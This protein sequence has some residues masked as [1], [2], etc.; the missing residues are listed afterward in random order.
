MSEIR[1]LSP[2][3][4]LNKSWHVNKVDFTKG[5]RIVIRGQE[6]NYV[7][8]P[9]RA[10]IQKHEVD[11]CYY[12]NINSGEMIPCYL[13]VPCQKCILCKDK[14]AVD[15]ATRVTCEGNYH[16]NCPWWITNTYNFLALPELGLQKRDFQ[17]FMKRLRERVSRVIGEDVRLRFVGVGEYGGNTARAHYHSVVYGLPSLPAKDILHLIEN[18]WS[19]RISIKRYKEI[20]SLYGKKAEDYT[21]TRLDKNGKLMYYL[22][23]GFVYVKPA[24]DSTPLYLAKYMFKP[25]F[26]TPE[27]MNPNFFLASRKNGIG[28]QYIVEFCKYHRQNPHCTK[29]DFINKHTGKMCHFTIPQYFKD[30][31]FPTPSKICPNEVK[32]AHDSFRELY[33][34]IEW[35]KGKFNDTDIFDEVQSM[36]SDIDKKYPF[37]RSV[38]STLVDDE[39]ESWCVGSTFNDDNPKRY[40]LEKYMTALM[41][42]EYI[43]SLKFD[44]EEFLQCL[45]LRDKHKGA[46]TQ[47][48]LNKP[49]ISPIDAA[50]KHKKRYELAKH[51]QYN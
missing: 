21:F 15:W 2:N 16:I 34:Q 43:M 46:M 19:I 41:Q 17:N 14:K 39:Y 40:Y 31:W 25:E 6:M 51:K 32:K 47:K 20:Q 38:K 27:G 1:C 28:Y 24:H 30:Y 49:P 26:N 9:R 37:F 45:T 35:I 3:I 23:L 10:K 7:P 33:A 44:T 12:Y 8:L 13:V 11:E 22:R 36:A 29:I 5:W 18:A 48:M 50:Y 42:Y 4:I